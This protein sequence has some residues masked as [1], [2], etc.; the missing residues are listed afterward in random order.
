M[1]KKLIHG[2]TSSMSALFLHEQVHFIEKNGYQVEVVCNNDPER[3]YDGLKLKH[4]P[5]EREI[6]PYRDVTTLY[7]L[8]KYLKAEDPDIIFFSTPKAGLLGMVAGYLNGTDT[9]IYAQW[10][11]RLETVTGLK[12][13]I[14]QTTEKLTCKLSTHTVIISDSLEE[15]MVRRN[16]VDQE[17][18]VRLGKG[19]VNGIDLERFRPEA[20]EQQ[21]LMQMKADLGIEP[22]DV[23]IGYM[24]RITKD[25]G[26][27]ELVEAFTELSYKYRNIKLLL[28]GDIEDG[29]PILP[30]NVEIIQGHERIIHCDY[31]NE[32]EYYYSMMD[33]FAFPTYR[34]GFGTVSIEAQAMQVPVVGFNSTGVKDT[35]V[36]D[37]TGLIV[38]TN[39]TAGL[40]EG[41]EDMIRHP[42]KRGEMG[43]NARKFVEEHFD[44]EL[45]QQKVLDFYNTLGASDDTDPEYQKA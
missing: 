3:Q 40:K 14:L 2:V 9:R 23:I 19:S 43:E 37:Q 6:S 1:Q 28:V 30:E 16:L 4:I 44:R 22:D 36:H 10:G 20:V 21:R 45:I 15:E 27:N 8:Y 13:V 32:P 18:V 7:S 38:W 25:K 17:K 5:F 33:V 29:D 42:L 12:K 26:T 11:L 34:E 31:T 39:D 24:G 41:L 35:I